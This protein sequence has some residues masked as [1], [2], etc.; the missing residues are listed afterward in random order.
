MS[1][2]VSEIVV[3]AFR[4][5]NFTSVGENT[6]AE[7]LVE[8]IPRLRNLISSL[9]GTDLGEQYR[10][11]FVPVSFVPEAPLRHPLTPSGTGETSGMPWIYPPAN[12]R[13]VVKLTEARTLYFP[14]YPMDGARMAYVDVGSTVGVVTL[15]G[16]GRKIEGAASIV[17][18][19]EAAALAGRRWFYR[20]DLADWIRIDEP[21]AADDEVPLP[22]EFD[23]LLVTGLAVRLAPR[24]QVKIDD[25]TTARFTDML[26][27]LKKRYKQSERMPTTHELRQTFRS[28]TGI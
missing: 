12:S 6:T 3:Q 8:A 22:E 9:F 27:R 23:D 20:A 14:A 24:F 13:L 7:E 18:G 21:L 28:E 1:T 15:N 2:L 5:G 17:D 25:T 4:E 10:D 19:A 11:W 16:N 26:D